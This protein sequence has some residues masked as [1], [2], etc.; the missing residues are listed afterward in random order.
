MP[1]KLL[2]GV[3]ALGV[4]F[5]L[6]VSLIMQ[7]PRPGRTP[8]AMGLLWFHMHEWIGLATVAVIAVHWI[9]SASFAADAGFAHLFPWSRAGRAAVR[10]DI[11]TL[12]AGRLPEGTG[13]GIAGL[14]H[15]FGLLVVSAMAIS[16]LMLFLTFGH[17]DAVAHKAAFLHSAVANFA[18]AYWYGH[19]GMALVHAARRDGVV[20]GMFGPRRLR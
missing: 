1:T 7:V 2:H 15:G 4:T 6:F 17:G 18:W 16:G 13:A 8:A 11:R 12:L 20:R 10:R 3:L 9:Y 5:Q 14:A 19:V